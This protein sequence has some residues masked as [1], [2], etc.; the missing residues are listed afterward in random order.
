MP[1]IQ[2]APTAIVQWYREPRT[3]CELV[4]LSGYKPLHLRA[5][6]LCAIMFWSRGE[7]ESYLRLL[8]YGTNPSVPEIV[9][10]GY[11]EGVEDGFGVHSAALQTMDLH[12]IATRVG[13]RYLARLERGSHGLEFRVRAYSQ[14]SPIPSLVK[15]VVPMPGEWS[16]A[17]VYDTCTLFGRVMIREYDDSSDSEHSDDHPYRGLAVLD[18]IS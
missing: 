9:Y 2:G 14:A 11:G 8:D 5:Q 17:E 18:F 15:F 13:R 10:Q 16:Q 1:I 7:K 4:V 6:K 3:S 12:G